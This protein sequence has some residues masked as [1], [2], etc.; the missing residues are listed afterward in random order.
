ESQRSDSA[1]IRR[2]GILADADGFDAPFFGISPKEAE[3]MDPQQRTLLEVAWEALES[4]GYAPENA[5]GAIGV[6]AGTHNNSAPLTSVLP[7]PDAVDRIGAL[8]TR[9]ANEKA[10]VAT[11]IARKMNLSGPALSIH[12]AC[13]TSLVATSVAVESLL[14]RGCDVA[15]AGGVA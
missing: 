13:S 10:D 14:A 5:G 9:A 12:T 6:F 3:V 7:R 2:R 1:Y 8:T 4:A 11:R 15:I